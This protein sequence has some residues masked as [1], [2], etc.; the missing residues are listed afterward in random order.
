MTPRY[1][2]AIRRPRTQGGQK[3]PMV[4]LDSF[5]IKRRLTAR[6]PDCRLI[7]IVEREHDQHNNDSSRYIGLMKTAVPLTESKEKVSIGKVKPKTS[8]QETG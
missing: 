2:F 7:C 3:K 1:N 8:L 4:G 5:R 6:R